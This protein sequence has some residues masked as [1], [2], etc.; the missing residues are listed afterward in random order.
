MPG[1]FI[2]PQKNNI[3]VLLC[4]LH[5]ILWEGHTWQIVGMDKLNDPNTV[6]KYYRKAMM[7]C[8]PDKT[9]TLSEKNAD[10]IFISN[11]VFAAVNEAFNEYKKEPGV[12]LK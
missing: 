3:K 10:K 8:H 6:K 2:Q 7:M 1:V 12:N 11:R 4:T 9:S 5:T